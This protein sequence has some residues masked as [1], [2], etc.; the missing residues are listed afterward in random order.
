MTTDEKNKIIEVLKQRGLTSQ[1]PRCNH[2]NWSLID[3]YFNQT[4]QPNVEGS[5]VI[6]G[7]SVPSIA[8]ACNNCGFISQHALG[9]LGLLAK[10]KES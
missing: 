5:I 6:G 1:C 8:L 2:P 7:P 4:I 9:A 10:Q 3:G